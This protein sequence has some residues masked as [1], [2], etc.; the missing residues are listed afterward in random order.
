MSRATL[1]FSATTMVVTATMLSSEVTAKHCD[2]KPRLHS[3][4]PVPRLGGARI[5]NHPPQH[6]VPVPENLRHR[7]PFSR[8]AGEFS[9]LK[10]A[11]LQDQASPTH[12]EAR[13]APVAAQPL[14]RIYGAAG[15]A[16]PTRT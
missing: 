2:A 1:G 5:T 16:T 8:T 13:L 7:S 14:A 15:Y 11:R 3:D 4:L 12:A 6:S 9:T 10:R